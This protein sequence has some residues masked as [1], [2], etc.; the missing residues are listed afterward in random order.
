MKAKQNNK[1]PGIWL[2]NLKKK[3]DECF[4]MIYSN[5]LNS[6][7]SIQLM[8]NDAIIYF[9]CKWW[10]FDFQKKK[11]H[12]FKR[13]DIYSFKTKNESY[14]KSMIQLITTKKMMYT[15]T[16]WLHGCCWY[17]RCDHRHHHNITIRD[18]LNR[19]KKKRTS[20]FFPTT[21]DSNRFP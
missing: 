5:F 20:H 10:N 21:F 16:F 8:F 18:R 9:F 7:D 17:S 13:N 11:I 6:F 12:L 19:S 15:C 3:F 2:S 14:P 1:L 4:E